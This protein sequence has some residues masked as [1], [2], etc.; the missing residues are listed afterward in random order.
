VSG[1]LERIVKEAVITYFK[2]L[3]Y[4]LSLGWDLRE[5]MKLIIHDS[6]PPGS[7][8]NPGIPKYKTGLLAA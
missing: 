2:V 4:H 3:S 8:L 7:D 1:E 5:T 6:K